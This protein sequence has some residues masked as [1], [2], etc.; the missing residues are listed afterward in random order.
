MSFFCE[1]A[2]TLKAMFNSDNTELR[3]VSFSASAYNQLVGKEK[4]T[5]A[6]N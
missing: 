1:Q 5:D 4:K 3:I 2:F 6:G